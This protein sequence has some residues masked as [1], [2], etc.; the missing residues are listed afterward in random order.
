MGKEIKISYKPWQHP[1]ADADDKGLRKYRY[2]LAVNVVNKEKIGNQLVVIGINPSYADD[3]YADPTICCV[4]EIAEANGYDGFIMANV[5]PQRAT[6]IDDQDENTKL[7]KNGYEEKNQIEKNLQKIYDKVKNLPC[8]DILLAYGGHIEDRKYL[9]D[10]L[11]K[12]YQKLADLHPNYKM[13]NVSKSGHPWHPLYA[14]R[15][16]KNPKTK[17]II[18]ADFNLIK[19]K[20]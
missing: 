7:P 20:P 8:R 12:I 11:L 19:I 15:Y 1:I 4:E 10:C 6:D 2:T 9:K 5:Y 16:A 17:T 3:N 13:I 18:P 14:L